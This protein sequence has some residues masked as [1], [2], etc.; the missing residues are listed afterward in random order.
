M[1]G[2]KYPT[3]NMDPKWDQSDPR[4]A[5]TADIEATVDLSQEEEVIPETLLHGHFKVLYEKEKLNTV[6]EVKADI[7]R[8]LATRIATL[9]RTSFMMSLFSCIR[10]QTSAL[11]PRVLRVRRNS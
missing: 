9:A 4:F 6:E 8:F 5:L 1:R 2:T 10:A 11:P 3:E 7:C